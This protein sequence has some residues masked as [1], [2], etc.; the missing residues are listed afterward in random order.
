MMFNLAHHCCRAHSAVVKTS[1]IFRTPGTSYHTWYTSLW[2][3]FCALLWQDKNSYYGIVCKFSGSISQKRRGHWT[4]EELGAISLNQPVAHD[5][6]SARFFGRAKEYYHGIVYHSLRKCKDI[7]GIRFDTQTV[8]SFPDK[9]VP[10]MVCSKRVVST[11]C[12]IFCTYKDPCASLETGLTPW[13]TSPY[14]KT[15]ILGQ[16]GPSRARKD[17]PP[18]LSNR[19]PSDIHHQ[20]LGKRIGYPWLLCMHT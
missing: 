17:R 13:L 10:I 20:Y 1:S 4:L 16:I 18:T 14:T 7:L 12:N 9:V 2:W 15:G 8:I 6:A 5:A 11:I 3:S 19:F